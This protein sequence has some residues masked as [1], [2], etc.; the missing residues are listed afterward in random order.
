MTLTFNPTQA[1]VKVNL[2]AK[3]QGRRSKGLAI[4]VKTDKHTHTHT[5][6]TDNITSS[7]SAG[8][9]M[10]SFELKAKWLI[11]HLGPLITNS[12]WIMSVDI[13][14]YYFVMTSIIVFV[15]LQSIWWWW[16]EVSETEKNYFSSNSISDRNSYIYKIWKRKSVRMP[17]MGSTNTV[18]FYE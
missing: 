5:K 8:G 10:L 6:A 2:H 15:A 1:R 7:P 18:L 16:S 14:H 3:N 9:K 12:V 4:G 17:K 13:R 11:I